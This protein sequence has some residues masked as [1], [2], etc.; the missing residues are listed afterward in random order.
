LQLLP[1]LRNFPRV[2]APTEQPAEFLVEAA[3]LSKRFKI[4]PRPTGRLLEWLTLGKASRHGD[5]WALRDINLQVRRGE[6][7]GIIGPNGSGKST[8]LKILTGVLTPTAGSIAIRGRL[9][10]LLELGTGTNS[11]LT[12]R[13]NVLSSAQLLSFPPGFAEEKMAEIEAFSELGDF[14]DRPVRMYSS[15]MAVRLAFSMFA[16]FRPEVFVVDEALSVGDIH[17]QQKCVKRID[18]MRADGTTFL[19]VSHDM[20]AIRRLC[21]QAILLHH[22]HSVFSGS[23]EEAVSRY[24]AICGETGAVAPLV[25]RS[26][27]A[28]PTPIP[29]HDQLLRH[30]VLTA[31][32]NRHGTQHAELLAA[33]VQNDLGE[34]SLNATMGDTVLITV[35]VRAN[36]DTADPAVGLHLYDRLGNLVFASGTRQLQ[37]PL[38][39]LAAGEER[40][41][42]LKL[43]LNVGPGEYTLSL[44]ITEPSSK[45]ADLGVI[46]DRWEGL[47]P[48]LV[49]HPGG[50]STFFGIA[51]LPLEVVK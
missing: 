19:F 46:H 44:G 31:A 2:N 43:T 12:G 17:F 9:L 3:H 42:R 26:V 49:A 8:L 45:G 10:S 30:T 37:S 18:E 38:P 39:A 28:N 29:D 20:G 15:G 21:N 22:G 13:Q 7:Y 6:C 35:L 24:Y 5:F 33:T 1:F 34:H 32:R 14:F 50:T 4:Y 16:C 27:N 41:V 11:L 25:K 47:G 36:S 40:L 23:P 51:K 48:L